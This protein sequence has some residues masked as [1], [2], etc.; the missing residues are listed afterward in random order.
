MALNTWHGSE[1]FEEFLASGSTG[2]IFKHS[3][4]CSISSE[5]Y[6]EVEKFLDSAPEVD[7]HVVLVVENRP[8]SQAVA[9]KL[10]VTHASPQIILVRD[11]EATWNASHWDITKK[12]LESVWA[13][14]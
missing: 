4:R 3:T 11:G 2:F 13:A 5:A 8:T 1:E 6:K 12:E 10:G 14:V 7:T 9:D